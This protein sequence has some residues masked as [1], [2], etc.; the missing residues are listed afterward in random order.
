M[1]QKHQIRERREKCILFAFTSIC[2][3]ILQNLEIKVSNEYVAY[4]SHLYFPF[5][6]GKRNELFENKFY[7]QRATYNFCF[8]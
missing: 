3:F 8:I 7:L 5:Y 6:C 1:K 4:T 2:W